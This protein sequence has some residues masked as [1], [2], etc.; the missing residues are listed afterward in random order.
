MHVHHVR[1]EA[2]FWLEPR[3]ELAG[4]FGLGPTRV[5]SARTILEEHLDE[6]R[7]AWTKHFGH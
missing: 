4:D 5:K 2:K 6:I 1:G 7:S 3:V